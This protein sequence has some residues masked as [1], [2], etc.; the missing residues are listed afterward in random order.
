MTFLFVGGGPRLGEVRRATE[1][2]GNVRFLPYQPRPR[3][4]DLYNAADVHLVTLRDE[5]AGLS[6]PSKYPAAL[7]AGK[8][9]L[10]VGGAGTRMCGEIEAEGLGWTCRPTAEDVRGALREALADPEA[11]AGMGRRAREVFDRRYSRK[12]ATA[13]W[14]RLLREVGGES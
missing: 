4:H 5:V 10:L 14:I 7:A 12:L 2:L 6:T 9:V 3:L 13:R 11:L 8:P 1:G